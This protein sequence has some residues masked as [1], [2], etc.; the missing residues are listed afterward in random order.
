MQNFSQLEFRKLGVMM[1]NC[2]VRQ[3]LAKAPGLASRFYL[4]NW[5]RF[6]CLAITRPV[7]P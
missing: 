1:E 3:G 7:F 5:D 2:T 6:T 4:P